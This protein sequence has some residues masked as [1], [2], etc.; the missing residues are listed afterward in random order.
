M[1]PEY[2]EDEIGFL[3]VFWGIIF[4][5]GIFGMALFAFLGLS[6]CKRLGR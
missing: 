6:R 2:D 5:I 4:P 3:V 1:K